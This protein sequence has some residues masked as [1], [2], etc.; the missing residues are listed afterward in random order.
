[1]A[2]LEVGVI[3]LGVGG[4]PLAEPLRGSRR[5]SWTNPALMDKLRCHGVGYE[6]PW[7]ASDGA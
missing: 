6:R 5:I 7:Y 4:I 1:M 2:A 3:G